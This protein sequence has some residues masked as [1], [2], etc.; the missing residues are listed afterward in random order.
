MS[1]PRTRPPGATRPASSNVVWPVP[2]PKSMICWSGCGSRRSMARRPAG[3]ITRSW[4]DSSD[5]HDEARAAQNS[6]CSMLANV[7][8]GTLVPGVRIIRRPDPS[9]DPSNAPARRGSRVHRRY[10]IGAT[11]PMLLA[12][13]LRGGRPPLG[14]CRWW[15][16]RGRAD[17]PHARR[18]TWT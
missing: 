5:I 9:V 14:R 15:P 4:W 7:M 11:A 13:L 1:T 10:R 16:G 18:A 12:P 6:A 8:V 3:P 2:Q 17:R